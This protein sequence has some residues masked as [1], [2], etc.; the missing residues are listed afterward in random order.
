MEVFVRRLNSHRR[1]GVAAV[2]LAVMLPLLMFLLLMTIDWARVFYYSV[3][4]TSAARQGALYGSDPITAAQ[5]PY[6]G[7]E[8]A[9]LAETT[10]LSPSPTVTTSSG[11]DADGNAYTQVT[12]A[13]QFKTLTQFPGIPKVTN[14]S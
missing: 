13:W 4:L 1:K 3:T 9:A 7:A 2:E 14:L 10:N 12:V 11:T 6:G 5:S 8:A